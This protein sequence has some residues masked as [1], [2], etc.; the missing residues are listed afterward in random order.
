MKRF[1][2]TAAAVIL[3]IS[4]T[5]CSWMDGSYVSV[6]P[7]QIGYLETDDDLFVVNNYSQLRNALTG[8]IDSGSEE[9][10]ITLVNYPQTHVQSDVENAIS[11]ATEVY[12]I[13]AYAV[14]SITYE[15]GTNSGQEAVSVHISYRHSKTEIDQIHN[16]R[17]IDGATAAIGDALSDFSRSLVLQITNYEDTDF[18][19][20]IE[21][22]SA[23]HPDIVMECP[24]ATAKIYPQQGLVRILELQLSYQTS[25][26]SLH[27]MQEQV[28]PI[29]AS[30]ALYVSP[31]AD[32]DVKLNQLYSFLMQRFSYTIQPSITPSYSLLVYGIGDSRAF[33]DVYGAMCRQ[34][35]L[36]AITV[37]G[38]YC[39]ESRFWN[40]V[41]CNDTYYH[42]DLL[43]SYSDGELKLYSDIE[44]QDYVWDYL[45]YPAC[46][47]LL[48][49][50]PG[51]APSELS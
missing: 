13:G 31:E 19:Q 18:I 42:I 1:F 48:S 37:S 27:L 22:Y 11:Y 15:H 8:L 17:G 9:A 34:A 6:T 26:D 45:S 49:F 50:D 44:M 30:A 25:R 32:D 39:G 51:A 21:N 40:I 47:A 10:L 38:T 23:A 43:K 7:H 28:S 5:G 36:E 16:V 33:A 4:L 2:R 3:V 12:P 20:L 41:R 29:F 35:G 14:D 24:Q 46:G